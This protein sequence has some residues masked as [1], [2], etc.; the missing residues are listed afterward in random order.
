MAGNRYEKMI[1]NIFHVF[2]PFVVIE[3]IMFRKKKILSMKE[4][5]KS[6]QKKH[7]T[8]LIEQKDQRL[9]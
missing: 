8:F 2:L 9:H 4:K 7:C 1:F 6:E 5:E 3:G